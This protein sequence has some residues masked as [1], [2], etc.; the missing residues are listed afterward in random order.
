MKV[1]IIEDE[2][3]AAEKLSRTI[4]QVDASI[5]VQAVLP[6]VK[7]SLRWL[8][9]HQTDLI[10]LDIHLSDGISFTIFEEISLNVPVIF[11]TAYDQYAIKAFQVNSIAYLL[12]PIRKRDLAASLEK[13]H[14]L[15][16]AYSLDITGLLDS[17][18]R[19]EPSYRRRFL[20]RFGDKMRK[21]ETSEVAYIYAMQKSV[22]M[23]TFDNSDFPIEFTLDKLE[24]DLDPSIFF[25]INRKFIIHMDAIKS[26]VAWSK[27]RVKLTLT[28]APDEDIDIVVSNERAAEFKKWLDQ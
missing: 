6:S 9:K 12:K 16:K 7:E 25:R 15:Q 1:V 22:F 8:R 17:L 3:L 5:E 23:K 14:S 18:Q 24:D 26:M 27:S 13:Y 2:Q 4:Q 11:T 28:P 20:I 21:I 10:F 19:K